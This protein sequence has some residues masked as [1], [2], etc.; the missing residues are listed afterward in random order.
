M[1]ASKPSQRYIPKEPDLAGWGRVSGVG[2][3]GFTRSTFGE[4]GSALGIGVTFV[5]SVFGIVTSWANCSALGDKQ[6]G[7]SFTI[8]F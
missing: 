3:S 2:F 8:N 6:I 1:P 7:K 5:G 4:A